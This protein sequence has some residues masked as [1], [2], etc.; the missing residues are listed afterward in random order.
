MP[1]SDTAEGYPK[2]KL[3]IVNTRTGKELT[4]PD[5]KDFQFITWLEEK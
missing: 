3:R 4:F 1:I 5:S 2:G